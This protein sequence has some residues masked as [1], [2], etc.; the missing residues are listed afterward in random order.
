MHFIE[1]LIITQAFGKEVAA[2]YAQGALPRNLLLP[3]A[4]GVAQLSQSFTGRAEF[5]HNYIKDAKLR[6]AYL[7][8]YLPAN[9]PK[10]KFLLNELAQHP[11][12]LLIK[13]QLRILDLGAGQGTATL[14]TLDYLVNNDLCPQS[15]H[16][17]A[18]ELS[19]P[20]LKDYQWLVESYL[21]EIAQQL[22]LNYTIAPHQAE[23]ETTLPNSVGESFDL[24][25]AANLV[26]ELFRHNSK[27]IALRAAWLG[28]KL[29]PRLA[30]DG[31]I[32]IIEPALKETTQALM[33]L[34]DLL[35]AEYP[36]SVYSPCPTAT[37][38]P[39]LK[40]S[41]RDWCHTV[42]DWQRPSIITQLDKLVGSRKEALKFSYL[43]LRKDSYNLMETINSPPQHTKW[44]LVSD[45][46][47]EKGKIS[48]YACGR[49]DYLPLVRLSRPNSRISDGRDT[50]K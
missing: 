25:I 12:K 29:L 28:E 37:P 41:A 8:Y 49:G 24:I 19:A 20:A 47:K 45:L 36:L 15:L 5:S 14:G 32:L 35:I 44:R 3:V 43:V 48:I 10:V 39:M 50:C 30:A 9:F 7:L 21:K 6:L 42:I 22:P 1:Q 27:A 33:Q 17:A 40:N 23:L 18:I 38:C 13:P 26:N 11:A 34:R 4:R 2:Q 16:L 31:S 46:H